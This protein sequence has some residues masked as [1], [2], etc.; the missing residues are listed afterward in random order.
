MNCQKEEI[1]RQICEGEQNKL[2]SKKY[3]AVLFYIVLFILLIFT[4]S[5]KKNYHVDETLTSSLANHVGYRGVIFEEGQIYDAL[6][7]FSN[8]FAVNDG[9]RFNFRN[10]WDN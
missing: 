3:T 5:E 10:V 6:E 7:V 2:S 9:E 4:I 1:Q 8:L